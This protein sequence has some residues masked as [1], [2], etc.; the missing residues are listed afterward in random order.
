[1]PAKAYGTVSGRQQ[2]EAEP[3]MRPAGLAPCSRQR[4]MSPY[5]GANNLRRSPGVGRPSWRHAGG[6]GLCHRLGAPTILGGARDAAGRVG[7]VQSAKAYGTVSGR[8][9]F[10]AEPEMRPAGLAPCSRQRLMSPYR[11]ANNLRRSP[12][13]GRP[14]WRRV[15]GK[16]LCHRLGAP[17]I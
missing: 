1:M 6:K 17:T 16:G 15:G 12:G 14:S 5:R 7:A 13:V 10:G 2:F 3:E 11:G 4:L 8:Q 9:Q